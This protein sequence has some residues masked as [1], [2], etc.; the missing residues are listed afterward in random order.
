MGEGDP[1]PDNAATPPAHS[2]RWRWW[3]LGLVLAVMLATV[4]TVWERVVA[5]PYL[6]SPESVPDA[7]VALV[8]GARVIGGRPTAFLA[9][10]LD[11]AVGLYSRHAVG[12]VLVSGN[13]DGHGYDEPDVMRAY[14][15][16]HGVPA[17]HV[18]VDHAGFD[19]EDTCARART[20]FGVDRAVLVT[21]AFHIARAVT[22]CRAA[23][24]TGY[25]VGV[26]SW[27]VGVESTVYGYFREY[28]A[29][30][31]AMWDVLTG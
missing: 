15:L 30:M 5:G 13:D 26:G 27:S 3:L 25:G 9:S 21:Q 10:R 20:V 23:G 8:F 29:A 31:K 17:A 7:P 6:R 28:F 24:V 2:R 18:L 1:V 19:T 12:A 4:P 14:L 16:A 22:L 11:V